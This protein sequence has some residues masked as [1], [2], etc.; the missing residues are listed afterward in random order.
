MSA[1]CGAVVG[2]SGLVQKVPFPLSVLPLA[3]VG[4]ALVHFA[5]Q[6][7]VML[8]VMLVTGYTVISTGVCC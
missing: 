7:G 3:A 6:L 4:F 1:A 5:L 8:V 2:N